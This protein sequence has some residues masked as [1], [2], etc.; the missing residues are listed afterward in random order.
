MP[1]C[2]LHSCTT[3]RYPLRNLHSACTP[4]HTPVP[5]PETTTHQDADHLAQTNPS[6]AKCSLVAITAINQLLDAITTT[7][8]LAPPPLSHCP[9]LAA[10]PMPQP[11]C[12]PPLA[13]THPPTATLPQVMEI[14]DAIREDRACQVLL[15]NYKKNG[16]RFWNQ[17]Y[18]A[19]L[20]DDEGRVTRYI[21]IQSDVTQEVERNALECQQAGAWQG[22]ARAHTRSCGWSGGA[23][24]LQ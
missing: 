23:E 22:C 4:L 17:F 5:A 11:S 7:P 15:L 14:R 2:I 19:P 6:S 20:R 8:P 18:L 16:E 24:Q 21:G 13:F 1:L 3:S 9:T 10:I 12:C